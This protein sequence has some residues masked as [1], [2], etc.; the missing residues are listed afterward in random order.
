MELSADVIQMLRDRP[1]EQVRLT[2]VRPDEASDFD[3]LARAAGSYWVADE[4]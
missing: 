3:A 4:D 1:A 2:L